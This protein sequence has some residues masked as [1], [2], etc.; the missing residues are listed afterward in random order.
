MDACLRTAERVDPQRA[1][2]E[3]TRAGLPTLYPPVLACDCKF[4]AWL[5][6]HAILVLP[7]TCR[8]CCG[9]GWDRSHA[10]FDPLVTLHVEPDTG[11]VYALLTVERDPHNSAWPP[12]L[13]RAAW[14]KGVQMGFTLDALEHYLSSLL[15]VPTPGLPGDAPAST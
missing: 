15:G 13:M 6:W 4:L 7:S 2:R 12:G 10:A 14:I 11:R 1:L 8:H 3:R 9:R 5:N